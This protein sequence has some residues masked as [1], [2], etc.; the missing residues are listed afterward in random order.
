MFSSADHSEGNIRD[1]LRRYLLSDS[2]R[3][4]TL[5]TAAAPT[6]LM[7]GNILSLLPHLSAALPRAPLCE[8]V[9]TTSACGE[10]LLSI[11]A[12]AAAVAVR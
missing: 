9:E 4:L 8:R 12:V 2:D 5:R 1:P 11:S 10:V 6:T 7:F 3:S